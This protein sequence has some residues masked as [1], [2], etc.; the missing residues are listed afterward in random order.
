[1]I[2]AATRRIVGFLIEEGFLEI[3]C[4]YLSMNKYIQDREVVV[5][6]LAFCVQQ[7]WLPVAG[8]H[9]QFPQ[10]PSK[11]QHRKSLF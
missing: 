4:I 8:G 9:W 1:M 7:A 5:P 3:L 2:M 11:S 10:S 6:V